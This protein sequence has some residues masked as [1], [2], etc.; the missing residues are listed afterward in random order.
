MVEDGLCVTL[1]PAHGNAPLEMSARR[2][3]HWWASL[4]ITCGVLLVTSCSHGSLAAGARKALRPR[5]P[6]F[7]LLPLGS[8]DVTGRSHGAT[9]SVDPAQCATERSR[10]VAAAGAIKSFR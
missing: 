5:S 6:R 7:Y 9:T 4:T 3:R 8:Q 1:S 2:R 10:M